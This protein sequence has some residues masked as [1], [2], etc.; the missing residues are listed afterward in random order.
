M[1]AVTSTDAVLCFSHRLEMPSYELE[2]DGCLNQ[3]IVNSTARFRLRL[4]SPTVAQ[5]NPT[6]DSFALTIRDPYGHSIAVRRRMVSSDLL[7]L[8]YQPMSVGEHQL[9]VLF[10]NTIDRQ[11]TID[12]IHDRSNCLS[13]FKPFGPGLQRAIVGLPTE[14]YVDLSQTIHPNIHFRLEPSY[15]AEIDYEQ[16][17][18]TVRYT[19]WTAGECPVH[20]LDN[21]HDIPQSPFHAHVLRNLPLRESPRLR[22][23]GLSKQIVLHQPVEFQVESRT[24]FERRFDSSP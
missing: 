6:V 19:P 12:V 20:I 17:M 16:Q 22:V 11:L 1:P 15:H 24:S 23:L 4:L 14:F 2:D 13:K 18:A 7:E 10:N 9:S 5:H 3:V 8:T 21:D